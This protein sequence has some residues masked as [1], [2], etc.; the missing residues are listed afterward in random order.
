MLTRLV[1]VGENI[2]VTITSRWS[3]TTTE[4]VFGDWATPKGFRRDFVLATAKLDFCAPVWRMLRHHRDV[5]TDGRS[6]SGLDVATLQGHTT[7][8]YTRLPSCLSASAV[9]AAS[10]HPHEQE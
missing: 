9:R 7:T 3:C 5:R 8:N 1:A 10:S 6:R 2:R 4:N